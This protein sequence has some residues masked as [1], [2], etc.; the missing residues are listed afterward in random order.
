M[1]IS[2]G[3]SWKDFEQSSLAKLSPEAA[4]YVRKAVNLEPNNDLRLMDVLNVS[5]KLA[6]ERPNEVEDLTTVQAFA[7]QL[8]QPQD[9]GSAVDIGPPSILFARAK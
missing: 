6:T 9:D 5:I 7:L 1:D 2:R 3:V 4:A 8:T